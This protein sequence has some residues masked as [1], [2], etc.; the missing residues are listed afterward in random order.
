MRICTSVS[1]CRRLL[2]HRT[3]HGTGHQLAIPGRIL[4]RALPDGRPVLRERSRFEGILRHLLGEHENHRC[5]EGTGG[6]PG[7]DQGHSISA[8]A[9]RDDREHSPFHR[10]RP[11]P[12]R[13][14]PANPNQAYH[15]DHGEINAK[16]KG[17]QAVAMTA[18]EINRYV[19]RKGLDT[20]YNLS[21]SEAKNATE[22]CPTMRD[23][24]KGLLSI[25]Q[26]F[27]LPPLHRNKSDEVDGR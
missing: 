6:T 13:P 26:G 5:T 11:C 4:P 15:E 25:Y 3:E 9:R 24:Y 17:K 18:E 22:L 1:G 2:D 14:I 10:H 16:I 23:R 27:R 8:R 21:Y 12:F 7:I 19:E 20:N